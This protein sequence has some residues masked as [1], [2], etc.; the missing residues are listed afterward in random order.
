MRRSLRPA[1]RRWDHADRDTDRDGSLGGHPHRRSARS[2]RPGGACGGGAA[3][4]G[5]PARRCDSGAGSGRPARRCPCGGGRGAK[6]RRP[7]Q[8]GH[9]VL[10]GG[11]RAACAAE[12]SR[13]PGAGAAGAFQRADAGGRPRPALA[14]LE[15]GVGPRPPLRPGGRRLRRA[16]GL[17]PHRDRG[18]RP[19]RP[20]RAA[21]R[22]RP[23]RSAGD[24]GG[25]SRP[26]VPAHLCRHGGRG[27]RGALWPAGRSAG[28]AGLP[29]ARPDP[30]LAGRDLCPGRG[31]AHDQA[32]GPGAGAGPAGPLSRRDGLGRRGRDGQCQP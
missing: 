25:E 13:H 3:P 15:P 18:E 14:G 8:R 20:L 2:A 19:R 17:F 16:A 21:G 28:R 23:R 5:R 31:G 6:R 7:L 29:P 26:C 32:G 12:G 9:R 30:R 11:G 1:E 27:G 10:L 24:G 4:A 22:R